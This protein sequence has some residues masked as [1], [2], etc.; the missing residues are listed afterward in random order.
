MDINF[1]IIRS[2]S[3]LIPMRLSRLPRV[4]VIC[5]EE[6]ELTDNDMKYDIAVIATLIT[7]L[8][9]CCC[10]WWWWWQE[11][12]RGDGIFGVLIL[13]GANE[14][15]W[16]WWITEYEI[17]RCCLIVED[18]SRSPAVINMI[19]NVTVSFQSD[20]RSRR[21]VGSLMALNIEMKK[22]RQK[23]VSEGGEFES[24]EQYDLSKCHE[25]FVALNWECD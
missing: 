15:H 24:N 18:H 9:I 19:M 14:A 16:L 25:L 3:E 7:I 8:S 21:W 6:I 17:K 5:W 23:R 22:T 13:H 2:V 4:I 11:T 20:F 1:L 12:F 10:C